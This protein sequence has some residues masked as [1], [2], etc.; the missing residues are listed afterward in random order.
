MTRRR[1]GCRGHKAKHHL[2]M[3][4][5]WT[6]VY[7]GTVVTCHICEGL[8]NP[9]PRHA[10]VDHVVPRSRGG[11]ATHGDKYNLVLACYRCNTRKGSH[12]P[13]IDVEM[14][15]VALRKAYTKLNGLLSGGKDPALYLT[16]QE[17]ELVG[18]GTDHFPASPSL[19]S[20]VG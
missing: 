16:D 14:P 4:F 18:W 20:R 17:K 11:R 10:T 3:R 6:C 12:S 8:L 19:F 13:P 15:S 9:G 5:N 7:C 1:R 2:A